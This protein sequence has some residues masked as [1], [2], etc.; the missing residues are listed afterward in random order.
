MQ[1]AARFSGAALRPVAAAR[2]M[3]FAAPAPLA[4]R[5]SLASAAAATEPTATEPTT[6]GETF[7]YQAEVG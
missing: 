5:R 7:Q 3:G 6:E 2:L 4:A 1:G